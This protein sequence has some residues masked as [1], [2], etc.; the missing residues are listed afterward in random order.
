MLGLKPLSYPGLLL[1]L[2]AYIG[3]IGISYQLSLQSI[4][5]LWHISSP[6]LNTLLQA[7][8]I[9][10]RY[11]KSLLIT[12]GFAPLQTIMCRVNLLKQIK[13]IV[14]SKLSDTFHHSVR[15]E[16]PSYVSSGYT[17]HLCTGTST[18]LQ[19]ILSA[20]ALL[21]FLLYLEHARSPCRICS[22]HL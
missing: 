17:F 8:I 3:S 13:S 6:T 10:Y 5:R 22:L 19:I 15:H 11:G 2:T 7:T 20:L 4:P 21:A 14:D 18:N 9:S 16:L 1:C 12:S